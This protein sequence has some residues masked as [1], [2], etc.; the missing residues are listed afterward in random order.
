MEDHEVILTIPEVVPGYRPTF[1]SRDLVK[2]LRYVA[3]ELETY[4]FP[5]GHVVV[6][7]FAHD[8]TYFH[9]IDR[10][11]FLSELSP[12]DKQMRMMARHMAEAE[13]Q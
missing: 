6:V 9:T 2:I 1:H 12:Q 3:R 8:G 13:T 5:E 7:T 4:E 11:I 10:D